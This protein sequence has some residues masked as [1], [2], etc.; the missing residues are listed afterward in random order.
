[1]TN[2]DE[3]VDAITSPS[4]RNDYKR[5]TNRLNHLSQ[6]QTTIIVFDSLVAATD[7]LNYDDGYIALDEMAGRL[8]R[9]HVFAGLPR[10]EKVGLLSEMVFGDVLNH[11]VNS[12]TSRK[13]ARMQLETSFRDMYALLYP[14]GPT[15]S[16]ELIKS[17]MDSI[18]NSE[19]RRKQDA[20][21]RQDPLT[22]KRRAF[23]E[24]FK[25]LPDDNATAIEEIKNTLKKVDKISDEV[26]ADLEVS[27]QHHLIKDPDI[28]VI[29]DEIIKRI[30]FKRVVRD[31]AASDVEQAKGIVVSDA[32]DGLATVAKNA[33]ESNPDIPMTPDDIDNAVAIGSDAVDIIKDI[34]DAAHNIK[35]YAEDEVR[36]GIALCLEQFDNVDE[37][38]KGPQIGD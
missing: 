33:V 14:T 3:L 27:E 34:K 35:E 31:H 38:D 15:L 1:M 5:Y 7:A 12:D 20:E 18:G 8:G 29:A 25:S 22:P 16:L 24:M 30:E 32:V 19:V 9:R 6:F 37:N 23:V 10:N 2:I 36:D 4:F 21:T 17:A 13:T 26:E 11:D 28:E